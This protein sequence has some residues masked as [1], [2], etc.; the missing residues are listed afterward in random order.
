MTR[1]VELEA[2][3]PRK[4]T[5]DDVDEEKGDVAICQCGLSG[6]FPFCDGSHRRTTDEDDDETYVYADGDRK[7]VDRV[8]TEDE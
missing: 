4:L 5:P 2:N 1:L 6:E 7:L 8:V 3:G